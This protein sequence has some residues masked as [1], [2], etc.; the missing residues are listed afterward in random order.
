M[1]L[2]AAVAETILTEL[3]G[4][5][6]FL[7]EV[8]LG[9]LSLDRQVRTLSGGE[10][11][12]IGL[13]NSLGSQLVDTLY[14]LDEPT[15]GLHPK[16]VSSLLNLLDKLRDIGNTVSGSRARFS[17]YNEG[18]PCVGIGSGIWQKRRRFGLSGHPERP[19]QNK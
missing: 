9:Y 18:G 15:V 14:V 10:S 17:S 8:G 1:R 13:A 6:T 4:R 5:L 3:L 2:Q 7:V 12:R 19:L 16:D 11:Q